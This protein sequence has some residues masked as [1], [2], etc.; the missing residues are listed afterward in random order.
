MDIVAEGSVAAECPCSNYPALYRSQKCSNVWEASG[1]PW[2]CMDKDMASYFPFWYSSIEIIQSLAN[3]H[4][5]TSLTHFQK[6]AITRL[7]ALPN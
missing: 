1:H 4:N 3:R 2:R 5:K 7:T 6:A